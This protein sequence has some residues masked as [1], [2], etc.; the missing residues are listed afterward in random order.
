MAYSSWS[1]SFGEQPSTAKWNIL[2]T[3]DASFN[4]GTGIA[5]LATNVTS[6]SNPYKFR[7]TRNAAANTGNA[8]FAV[9]AMDTEQYDTNNNHSAGVYT[10]PVA[11]FYHFCGGCNVSGVGAGGTVV[12]S[13]F[14]NGTEYTRGQ[15]TTIPSQVVSANVAD[16]IQLAAGDTVDVRVYGAAAYALTVS[17]TIYNFFSGFL[18]SQ[19]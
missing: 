13:L 1:V 2:G 4:N 14:K 9:I 10:A 3:N 8:A 11:G 12:L 19:T 17:N 6:I 16:T 18:V 15:Q 5:N 7:A